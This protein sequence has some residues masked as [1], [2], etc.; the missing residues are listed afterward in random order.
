MY[1][2]FPGAYKF[3]R[4][5]DSLILPHMSYLKKISSNSA[6]GRSGINEAHMRY[7]SEKI[8]LLKGEEKLVNILFDEIYVKSEV[9]YKNGKLEGM[10][11]TDVTQPTT[12]I[13]AVMYTSV[14]SKNKDVV[15]LF[16]VQNLTADYLSELIQKI[17]KDMTFMGFEIL[18]LISDNNIT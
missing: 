9:T 15:G 17:I 3:L 12:T 18:T 4:S 5:T 1:Y 16:P 14:L 7:L 2:S 13:L 6:V 11:A 8:N 10:S